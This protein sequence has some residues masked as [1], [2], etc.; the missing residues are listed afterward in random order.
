MIGII[1]A[2]LQG[3]RCFALSSNITIPTLWF[4]FDLG[5]LNEGDRECEKKRC[6][7]ASCRLKDEEEVKEKKERRRRGGGGREERQGES[8]WKDPTSQI[9][10]ITGT[11]RSQFLQK[12]LA[13]VPQS[14]PLSFPRLLCPLLSVSPPFS[15]HFILR[16]QWVYY[17]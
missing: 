3:Q 6:Q 1:R 4:L 10:P 8:K 13:A 15:F 5:L 17:W 14:L 12:A 7:Q 16:S 2:F 9:V 11:F